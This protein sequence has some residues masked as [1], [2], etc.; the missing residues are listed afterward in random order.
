MIWQADTVYIVSG[1]TILNSGVHLTIEPGAI[2]KF[3]SDSKGVHGKLL[4]NGLLTAQGTAKQRIIFTSIDEDS[5][6]GDTLWD[7]G[8]TWAMPGDWDGLLFNSLSTGSILDNVV[9][10]YGGG[11]TDGAN[12][13]VNG[14]AINLTHASIQYSGADGVQWLN[15]ATGQIV[16]NEISHNHGDGIALRASS[17]PVVQNNTIIHNW[18]NAIVQEGSCFPTI[19]DNTV[20]GNGVNG[21]GIGGTVGTGA[22]YLNANLPYVILQNAFIEP[23]PDLASGLGGQIPNRNKSNCPRRAGGQWDAGQSDCL[24]LAQRR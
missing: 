3:G 18:D 4:V 8:S 16:D 14:A 1:A 15:N 21:V 19:S 2:I 9:V 22:W 6:G 20:Y 24:H 13:V 12:I 10:A 17:A 5:F 23:P 11:G 7:A